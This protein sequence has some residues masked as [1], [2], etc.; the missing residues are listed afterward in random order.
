MKTRR[1]AFTLIELLVVIAI[2]AVLIAL[3]LPA[4]QSAREAARRAQCIN[5]LK[6][7]GLACHNYLSSYQ[8]LPSGKVPAYFNVPGAA[9]WARWSP[10]SSLLQFV[11]Q[12][13]VFNT[14]NFALPPVTPAMNGVVSTFMPAYSGPNGENMTGCNTQ[15]NVFLC[16]SDNP[17]VAD[18]KGGTNYLGNTGAYMCDLGDTNPCTICTDSPTAQGIFYYGSRVS[19]A[20]VTD[21]T[22]N[23]AFFGE[24]LRGQGTPDFRTDLLISPNQSTLLDTYQ[25]CIALP[26]GSPPLTSVQGISWSLA[27]MCCT[28]YNHVGTPNTNSCAGFPNTG[29]VNMSMQVPPSS[30]HPGGVNMLFGDGSVKFVKDSVSLPTWRAL[31]TRNG[32]EV[33]SADAY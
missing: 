27:D 23:T 1:S 32:G 12:G 19:I 8:V 14:L 20:S 9:G 22:S 4:V 11:E 17:P 13:N 16:P 21:G 3:L 5:N 2:I 6:Q 7:I 30:R 25:V 24:K 29:M 33:I 18:W 26:K 31:G 10:Q 28:T 15:I